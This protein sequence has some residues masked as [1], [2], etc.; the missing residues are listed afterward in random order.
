MSLIFFKSHMT[1]YLTD[2]KGTMHIKVWGLSMEDFLAE[3]LT[4]TTPF[5]L[6]GWTLHAMMCDSE[7]YRCIFSPG[8]SWLALITYVI[9]YFPPLLNSPYYHHHSG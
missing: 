6:V 9:S 1:I 7:I 8:P 4:S 5:L 3:T 2:Q